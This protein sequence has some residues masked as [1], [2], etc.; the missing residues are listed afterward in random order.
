MKRYC[1]AVLVATA[2]MLVASTGR[3]EAGPL[4][5]YWYL[6]K[7][8]LADGSNAVGSPVLATGPTHSINLVWDPAAD[9]I[10]VSGTIVYTG[11]GALTTADVDLVGEGFRATFPDGTTPLEG[12][13]GFLSHYSAL[14]GFL[15]IATSYEFDFAWWLFRAWDPPDFTFPR[16]PAT[17]GMIHYADINFYDVL[18]DPRDIFGQRLSFTKTATNTVTWTVGEEAAVPEPTSLLLFGTGLVGAMRAWRKR[19][20]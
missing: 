7:A 1:V 4:D 19:K 18:N 9:G 8:Q 6:S 15:P 14:N 17:A 20:A 3:V 13:G 2:L 5:W 16:L 10:R 12:M 11:S